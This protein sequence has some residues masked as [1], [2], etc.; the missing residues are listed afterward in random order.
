MIIIIIQIMINHILF[1]N[2][3]MMDNQNIYL[4]MKQ[5][6]L[7]MYRPQ[8]FYD[9]EKID[10]AAN[11]GFVCGCEYKENIN[12][13][14]KNLGCFT[15]LYPLLNINCSLPKKYHHET[16]F[17]LKNIIINEQFKNYCNRNDCLL[18]EMDWNIFN[19]QSRVYDKNNNKSMIDNGHTNIQYYK[20]TSIVKQIN[21]DEHKLGN[22]YNPI[23]IP[24][25]CSSIVKQINID[26]HKLGNFYNPILIPKLNYNL[27]FNLK[28]DKIQ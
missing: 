19:Y 22:F 27:F 26:E 10:I 13:L 4:K 18:F 7:N 25:L 5:L 3:L 17:D 8:I 12:L 15:N 6:S 23:L 2:V 20:S 24:N 9:V 11:C 14:N 21:I 16:F 28:F 1:C